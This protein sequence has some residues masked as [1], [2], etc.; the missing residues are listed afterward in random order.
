VI[1]GGGGAVLAP[2]LAPL[3]EGEV[4]PVPP[5]QDARLNNVQGYQKYGLHLWSG[6]AN[7]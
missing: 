3:L 6:G 5:E 2:Y 4:I 1:S 7:P